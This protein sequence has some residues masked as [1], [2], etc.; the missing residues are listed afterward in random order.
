[1]K[2][3]IILIVTT[4][5]CA[6]FLCGAADSEPLEHDRPEADS[7]AFASC[8][9][10]EGGAAEHRYGNWIFRRDRMER[11]CLDCRTYDSRDIDGSLLLAD[12]L[13]GQWVF[14]GVERGSQ[15]IDAGRLPAKGLD[16]YFDFDKD[17]GASLLGTDEGDEY[18]WEFSSYEKGEAESGGLYYFKVLKNGE[19]YASLCMHGSDSQRFLVLEKDG[20]RCI[21]RRDPNHLAV[22][23][24]WGCNEE[25]D[26]VLKL[27]NDHRFIG[28][29]D[30][31]PVSG[32]WQL[33][34]SYG[35]DES[36]T[37]PLL[38][39]FGEKGEERSILALAEGLDPEKNILQQ[40]YYMIF[41]LSDDHKDLSFSSRG[42]GYFDAVEEAL[43][44]SGKWISSNVDY[45]NWYSGEQYSIPTTDYSISL[46][47]GNSVHAVL[48]DGEIT[49]TWE[50]SEV[51]MDM[52]YTTAFYDI[53][54]GSSDRACYFQVLDGTVHLHMDDYSY[55]MGQMD[56]AALAEFEK[57]IEMHSSAPL[58]QWPSA[59]VRT[60]DFSSYEAVSTEERTD[61]CSITFNEDGTV[62]AL[63]DKE[64]TGT[65]EPLRINR[66]SGD[67]IQYSYDLHFDGVGEDTP[68]YCYLDPEEGGRGVLRVS[69]LSPDGTVET[70][71]QFRQTDEAYFAEEAQIAGYWQPVKALWYNDATKEFESQDVDTSMY[72]WAFED[73]TFTGKL[74]SPFSGTW[75]YDGTNSYSHSLY[76]L[77]AEN[78]ASTSFVLDG[79]TLIGWYDS[80]GKSISV[81]FEKG[82]ALENAEPAE[83]ETANGDATQTESSEAVA[84]IPLEEKLPGSWT[85]KDASIAFVS[86]RLPEADYRYFVFNTDGSFEY[87]ENSGRSFSGTWAITG[88]EQDVF[89]SIRDSFD[90]EK[91]GLE[92][93]PLDGFDLE[94]L[95]LEA[96]GLGDIV[97][98][99]VTLTLEDGSTMELTLSEGEAEGRIARLLLTLSEGDAFS[100]SMYYF[101]KD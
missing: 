46:G 36:H 41:E 35:D 42:S 4:V 30:Q 76:S 99:Q 59:S 23:G 70:V 52:G 63:L 11:I 95:D 97:R 78:G 57:S 44:I 65:W 71:Y 96:Y 7:S 1:M 47:E 69:V 27:E 6:I 68:I 37:L 43:A 79:D 89:E 5:L 51:D 62:S 92:E 90:P 54:T 39:S 58:G 61:A 10:S 80:A 56:E 94:N 3:R 60:T 98:I 93:N 84:D 18:T 74:L 50:L 86:T 31:E 53:N 38:L 48:M 73:G 45:Y 87:T 33:R 25:G 14:T 72:I 101:T 40:A 12:K 75:I 8:P 19:D 100:G 91:Y 26:Y 9:A 28:Y 2:K 55:T 77:A 29:F 85:A 15:F 17:G 22:A 64:Y 32:W 81:Y 82:E 67:Q 88:G 13:P 16:P 83:A 49:G 24:C 66:H 20:E 21:L 34:P